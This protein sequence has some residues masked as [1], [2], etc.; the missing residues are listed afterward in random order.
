MSRA[1]KRRYKARRTLIWLLMACLAFCLSGCGRNTQSAPDTIE[2]YYFYDG[3]CESCDKLG[4]FYNELSEEL[5]GVQDQYPYK[6]IPCNVFGTDGTKTEAEFFKKLGVDADALKLMPVP[7]LVINGNIYH[8][9]DQ[10]RQN[11]R[12]AYLAAGKAMEK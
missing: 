10:V 1:D 7:I 5:Q 4:E 12:E 11:L 6:V 8:G 9:D 3:F 2:M